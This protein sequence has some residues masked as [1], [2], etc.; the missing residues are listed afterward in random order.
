MRRATLIEQAVRR[1]S[2]GNL[3]V[4]SPTD[5]RQ[6]SHHTA[7]TFV[8]QCNSR[9]A[10][11]LTDRRQASRQLVTN[12]RQTSGIGRPVN[13]K[14]QT[15]IFRLSRQLGESGEAGESGES[16]EAGEAGD[17]GED[18]EVGESG[19]AGETRSSTRH[20]M[21]SGAGQLNESVRT[22]NQQVGND[23]RPSLGQC[24][25]DKG[26]RSSARLR[27]QSLDRGM[28]RSSLDQCNGGRLPMTASAT[29][30]SMDNI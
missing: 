22:E 14:R 30:G 25:S 16:G 11:H 13:G 21:S 9:G 28:D 3:L 10:G 24:F 12:N 17:A 1:Q 18:A 19:E 27:H 6:P 5:V 20:R 29:V 15:G 8:L 7:H 23:S 2:S 26:H 4:V